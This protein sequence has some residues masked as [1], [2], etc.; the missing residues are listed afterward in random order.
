MCVSESVAAPLSG[1]SVYLPHGDTH[2][3][4]RGE[5][6]SQLMLAQSQVF[7]RSTVRPNQYDV[8]FSPKRAFKKGLAYSEVGDF[9]GKERVKKNRQ[10]FAAIL[11]LMRGPFFLEILQIHIEQMRY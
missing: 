2:G 1:M 11:P 8:L 10:A 6:N 3:G 5:A 9:S 4:A 7:Q